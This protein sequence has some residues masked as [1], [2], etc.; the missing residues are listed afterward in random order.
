[1][2]ILKLKDCK[3]HYKKE[4][5]GDIIILLHGLSDD[6]NYWNP[7]NNYFKKKY[8]VI[9]VDLRGH[10]KSTYKKG[11]INNYE[12]QND[13]YELM[14]HLNIN[15]ATFIGFSL[16]GIISMNF[17]LKHPE[18]VEKL[19]LMST[20]AKIDENNKAIH[21]TI[22]KEVEKGLGNF[23]DTMIP[24]V[25]PEYLIKENKELI[26]YGR[27][28]CLEKNQKAI[29]ETIKAYCQINIENEI[30]TIKQDTLI[31]GG[32]EDDKLAP[33][34]MIIKLYEEI[35]NSQ[36]LFLKNTKHNILLNENLEKICGIIDIFLKEV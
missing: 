22:Y 15:K 24:F 19:I 14:K 2:S 3:L 12:L 28:K 20:F 30:K 13:I 9:R 7:L 27:T 32:S 34:N 16:G 4:G 21:K 10:G 5:S 1:M 23:Y 8:T 36:I 17:T 35:K 26:E 11:T 18:M 33:Y 25:L 29:S 6:I 31:I